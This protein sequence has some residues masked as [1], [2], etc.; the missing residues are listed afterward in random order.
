MALYID[1]FLVIRVLLDLLH[2][3]G[4][5]PADVLAWLPDA[6]LYVAGVVF[7][8]AV[9]WL[10]GEF[11]MKPLFSRE[12][13]AAAPG[14][15][16]EESKLLQREIGRLEGR[17]EATESALRGELERERR[18]ADRLEAELRDARRPWWRRMIGGG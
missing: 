2:L 8:G 6:L 4:V 3:L 9:G 10:V 14:D 17:L 1:I 5:G 15:G 18:R 12:G 11:V 16:R 7:S 13:C